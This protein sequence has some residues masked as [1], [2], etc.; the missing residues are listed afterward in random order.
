MIQQ[1]PVKWI[2]HHVLRYQ[3]DDPDAFLDRWA[4]LNIEMDEG[5]Q[6]GFTEGI[7][8]STFHALP[9]VV[10]KQNEIGW[11]ALLEGRPSFSW[12]EVQ[13]R[14]YEWL[15]SRRSGLRWPTALIQ[16]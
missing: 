1:F 9:V 10:Q 4:T 6:R 12:S 13:Q 7:P 15:G 8:V 2:P 11:Q 14:Y 5:W 3:D 16:K